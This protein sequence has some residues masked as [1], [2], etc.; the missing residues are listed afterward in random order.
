MEKVAIGVLSEQLDDAQDFA[1]E[2]DERMAELLSNAFVTMGI[3]EVTHMRCAV[4]GMQNGFLREALQ[5]G[6]RSLPEYFA[7]AERKILIAVDQKAHVLLEE[8]KVATKAIAKPSE[9]SLRIICLSDAVAQHL[10][11]HHYGNVWL[12]RERPWSMEEDLQRHVNQ[13]GLHVYQMNIDAERQLIHLMR[14]SVAQILMRQRVHEDTTEVVQQFQYAMHC[15]AKEVN[16][17]IFESWARPLFE[18]WDQSRVPMTVL[19]ANTIY[20]QEALNLAIKC[21][22][23]RG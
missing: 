3:P 18:Q 4:V 23:P 10:K 2:M 14:D 16:T 8:L 21:P 6:T 17:I 22:P 11:R 15:L 7:D 1:D 12:Q 5:Y 19:D 20:M 9:D 13:A